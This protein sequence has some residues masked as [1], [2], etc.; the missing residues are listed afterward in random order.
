MI[1]FLT[2]TY[3]RL[4]NL[5]RCLKSI[6][7]QDIPED[8]EILVID[9][10]STDGTEEYITKLNHPKI[11]YIHNVKIDKGFRSPAI[12][13]NI[14][15]VYAKGDI[16]I[17]I[18]ADVIIEEDGIK[19][20][21]EEFQKQDCYLSCRIHHVPMDKLNQIDKVKDLDDISDMYIMYYP[22][23][24]YENATPF[25]AIYKK[26]WAY[27]IGLYD[28]EYHTGGGEDCDFVYRMQRIT[29]TRW[30][31]SVTVYHQDH[32]KFNGTPL[33]EAAYNENLKR[34]QSVKEGAE[35]RHKKRILVMASFNYYTVPGL[36]PD[37]LKQQLLR[38]GHTCYFY[39]PA[40]VCESDEE[41]RSV[42]YEQYWGDKDHFRGVLS[43]FKPDIIIACI[44][45]AYELLRN[46]KTDAFKVCWYGDMREPYLFDKYK[47]IF[48][49]MLLTNMGQADEYEERL[50]IPVCITN[51][52]VSNTG[53]RN[54]NVEKKYDVCFAGLYPSPDL[55]LE[56]NKLLDEIKQ[57]FNFRHVD[58]EWFETNKLYNQSKI[59]IADNCDQTAKRY[60]SNRFFNAMGS[61]SFVLARYF[62][63]I[64]D[65]GTP[66]V[67][68]VCFKT[69]QEAL[70]KIQY[71]LDNPNK[72]EAIA[73][74]GYRHF[75]RIHTWED[76]INGLLNYIN[77]YMREKDEK[78]SK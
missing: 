37:S 67:H 39:D 78:D 3:N 31:P 25:C 20:L 43:H 7:S 69:N 16:I 15:L 70:E 29:K 17:Q 74:E 19:K 48:D 64:E 61:G 21:Y 32:P 33:D 50:G 62:E 63:G 14:G 68:F 30:L 42:K 49:M 75:H 71:Y 10:G 12:A 2:T 1:T 56:R 36:L 45:L 26:Q 8:Y 52:A 57:K 51:F 13:H 24:D 41:I 9:D 27:D 66:G 40:P 23:G 5:K 58:Q 76:N 54:L 59:I 18:G 38:K 72:R 65:F 34:L 55:H 6:Y 47:G 35:P 46:V 4:G 28:E 73:K 11:R 60:T 44:P 53:H 22:D 77:L